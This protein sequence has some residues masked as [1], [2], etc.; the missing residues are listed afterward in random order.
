ML[1][2]LLLQLESRKWPTNSQKYVVLINSCSYTCEIL[3][4]IVT[5]YKHDC[6]LSIRWV[7]V[8]LSLRLT[9][10]ALGHEGIWRSVCIDPRFL[11]LC[12]SRRW[13]VKIPGT[14]GWKVWWAPEPNY[15][16]EKWKKKWPYRESNSGPLAVQ[17]IASSYNDCATGALYRRQVK[18]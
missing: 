18:L 16:M 8:A 10:Q 6:L 5:R 7:K 3:V 14:I 15:N 9:N 1:I 17:S 11:H 12:T 2:L 4:C 13:A